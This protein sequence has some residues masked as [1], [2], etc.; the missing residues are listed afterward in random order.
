[1]SKYTERLDDLGYEVYVSIYLRLRPDDIKELP[2]DLALHGAG[3]DDNSMAVF[4]EIFWS[5]SFSSPHDRNLTLSVLQV[6]LVT[7]IATPV[8][9]LKFALNHPHGEYLSIPSLPCMMF[10]H[11]GLRITLPKM[12][13]TAQN[14]GHPP[15]IFL[16]LPC[17]PVFGVNADQSNLRILHA[18]A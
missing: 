1:M 18:R 5:F 7:A 12:P 2:P 14:F 3:V 11:D 6:S 8:R 10:Y 4:F 17:L 13:A 9:P 16:L 15:L